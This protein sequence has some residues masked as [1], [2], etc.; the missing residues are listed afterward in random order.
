MITVTTPRG[1]IRQT[2]GSFSAASLNEQTPIVVPS[3]RGKAAA[4]RA[5]A[6][7]A[8]KAAQ[9]APPPAAEPSSSR[10]SAAP[11]ALSAAPA[12]RAPAASLPQSAPSPF[13]NPHQVVPA[14]THLTHFVVDGTPIMRPAHEIDAM[15]AK[16]QAQGMTDPTTPGAASVLASAGAPRDSGQLEIEFNHA[17]T[18][19]NKIKS[20]F[21]D[22][23]NTYKQFLEILQTYQR[24]GRAITE[25]SPFKL[26]TGLR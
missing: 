3:G 8:A 15:K 6:A 24:D 4:A 26:L 2:A 12:S 23:P 21:K 19:V 7:A 20:R 14:P 25:V 10:L 17:I 11:P 22:K 16:A 5:E 18:Y 1:I 9:A 13:P